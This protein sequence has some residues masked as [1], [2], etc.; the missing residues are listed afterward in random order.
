M[1]VCVIKELTYCVD[2][3]FLGFST[4]ASCISSTIVFTSIVFCLS[5]TYTDSSN[6]MQSNS[7][8]RLYKM[9]VLTTNLCCNKL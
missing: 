9:L 5:T 8:L 2:C 1:R 4:V 7:H 6:M 3:S